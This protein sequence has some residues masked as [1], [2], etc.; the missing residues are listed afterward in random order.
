MAKL[1][2][3]LLSFGAKGQI[4]KTLVTADWKGIKYA[5]QYTIPANPQTSEQ[6][7]TRD[8]F[9]TLSQLW[10][11]A[12]TLFRAPWTANAIGRAYTDRN[13]LVAENMPVLRAETDM[14]NFIASPGAL[15]GPPLDAISAATGSNAGEI[16]MTATPPAPPT[17]WTLFGVTFGAFPDQDPADPFVGPMVAAQDTTSTYG[18]TLTG[19]PAATL[20][21]CFA[22]PVWTR[23]DGKTAYGPSLL[24]QATSAA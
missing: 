10:L 16:D 18:V 17:G 6:T 15:G 21:Q 1:T 12:P 11:N 23:P 9:R 5:R 4:G 14:N 19:L 24:D 13:K 2:G 20:C 8:T 7:V 22:F 3:P